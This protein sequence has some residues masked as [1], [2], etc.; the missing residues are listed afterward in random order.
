MCF[1]TCFSCLISLLDGYKVCKTFVKKHGC[2]AEDGNF[3]EVCPVPNVDKIL[4][5]QVHQLAGHTNCTYHPYP[6]D[7]AATEAFTYNE[8]HIFTSGNSCRAVFAVVYEKC[9]HGK[10]LI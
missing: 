4:F 7:P 1:R 3:V 6:L 10:L 8:T 2:S 5:A 9:R